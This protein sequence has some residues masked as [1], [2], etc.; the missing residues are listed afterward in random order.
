MK[1]LLQ[2]TLSLIAVTAVLEAA[3]GHDKPVCS[4]SD[5]YLEGYIQSILNDIYTPCHVDVVV[6]KGD[7]YLSNVPNICIFRDN[8]I[9]QIKRIPG[10]CSVQIVDCPP[11]DCPAVARLKWAERIKPRIEGVWFPVLL[12]NTLF[13]PIIADPR[14]VQ[15]SAA[16]RM[17]DRTISPSVAAVSLG[18]EIPIYRWCNMW[19]W[20][21]DLQIGLEGCVWA[22]F[23]LDSPSHDLVNADYYCGI[24]VTYAFKNWSFRARLYHISSHLGDEY[25]IEH[26]HVVR[27]NPSIEALDLYVSCQLTREIRLYGGVGDYFISD[28]TFWQLPLY[29]IYGTEIKFVLW[30]DTCRNLIYKPFLAIFLQNR[31]M[32][33]WAFN[34]NYSIGMELGESDGLGK[35]VRL[36]LE[37]YDGFSQEGQLQRLRTSYGQ[38]KFQYCY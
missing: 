16:Y 7:V 2:I 37:W 5:S 27:R 21:G 1:R 24:P 15:Y 26:P 30:E 4:Y 32:D 19:Q 6:R 20:E 38:I 8:V 28:P 34:Q 10:V 23:N 36:M 17:G 22:V 3:G 13:N 12:N 33:N 35:K 9:H 14:Q 18:D 25:L 31:E 11:I 29:L